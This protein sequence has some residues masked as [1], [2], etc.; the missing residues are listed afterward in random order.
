MGDK[1]LYRKTGSLVETDI[2]I[3]VRTVDRESTITRTGY[4]EVVKF[5]TETECFDEF[6]KEEAECT[7]IGQPEFMDANSWL[8]C[9]NWMKEF[10]TEK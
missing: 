10:L 9:Y 5:P 3:Q 4:G 8:M 1:T 7:K 2:E 6:K